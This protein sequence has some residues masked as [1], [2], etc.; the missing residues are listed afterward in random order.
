MAAS[1]EVAYFNLHVC[2]ITVAMET[3]FL[4]FYSLLC[5]LSK[6]SGY[7]ETSDRF[8]TKF[9]QDKSDSFSHALFNPLSGEFI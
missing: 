3:N 4:T 8:L 2:R 9:L 5:N 1:F 6:K 7:D